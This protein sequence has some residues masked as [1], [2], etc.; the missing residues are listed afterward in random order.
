M[1]PIVGDMNNICSVDMH[2]RFAHKLCD[3]DMDSD[4]F[5]AWMELRSLQQ[6]HAELTTASNVNALRA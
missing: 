6:Q 3:E 5:S 1:A 4:T 2:F